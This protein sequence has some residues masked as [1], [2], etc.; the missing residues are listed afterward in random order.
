MNQPIRIAGILFRSWLAPRADLFDRVDVTL[1]ARADDFTS[2]TSLMKL[3]RFALIARLGLL[4]RVLRE[5]WSTTIGTV[6]VDM[7][8]PI[9]RG[10]RFTLSTRIVGWDGAWLYVEQRFSRG[11]DACAIAR[12]Q[13]RMDR[14]GKAITIPELLAEV[15]PWHA[16]PRLPESFVSLFAR[17]GEQLD[18][19]C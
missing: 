14:R 18:D 16:S 2:I 1:S 15:G 6:E 5:R 11:M 10:A 13:V 4:G 7:I 9:P 17:R 8:A 19:I 3:G 12:V